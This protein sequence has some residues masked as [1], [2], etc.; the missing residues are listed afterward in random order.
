LVSVDEL[1][2]GMDGGWAMLPGL[3]KAR[4]EGA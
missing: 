3:F 2:E 1:L 4:A